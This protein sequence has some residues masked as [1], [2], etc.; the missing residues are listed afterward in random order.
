VDHALREDVERLAS[1]THSYEELTAVYE[2]VADGLPR[3]PLAETLY[4]TLSHVHDAKL[5]DV[6]EAERA[7]KKILEFDASVLLF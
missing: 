7:L 6:D 5:D 2:E 4:R 3:G 1:E